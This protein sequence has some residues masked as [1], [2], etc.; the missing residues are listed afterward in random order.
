MRLSVIVLNT[1]F[2][3]VDAISESE[4]PTV[5]GIALFRVRQDT[6]KG[7]IVVKPL[8]TIVTGVLK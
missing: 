6:V 7:G 5:L 1:T 8:A 2:V 4:Y 3:P